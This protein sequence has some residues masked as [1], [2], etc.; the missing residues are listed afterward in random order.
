MGCDTKFGAESAEGYGWSAPPKTEPGVMRVL[1][2]SKRRRR[3]RRPLRRSPSRRLASSWPTPSVASPRTIAFRFVRF[4]GWW[5]IGTGVRARRCG[6][7][8]VDVAAA[9]TSADDGFQNGFGMLGRDLHEA[10]RR[11]NLNRADDLLLTA[12]GHHE[13]C[14]TQLFD[15]AHDC[16]QPSIE[17]PEREVILRQQT[18]LLK[19]FDGHS[20]QPHSPQ[21]GHAL[22]HSHVIVV[23]RIER[24]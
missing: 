2:A 18:A 23:R 16:P 9:E 17:Q 22:M 12:R 24:Q 14:A 6:D 10:D 15:I 21:P 4:A 1:I 8:R 13:T 20:Q 7:H 11:Q 3:T 19:G 5:A